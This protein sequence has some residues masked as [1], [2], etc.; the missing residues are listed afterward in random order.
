MRPNDG[1]VLRA[2]AAEWY[3]VRR[4]ERFHFR[5]HLSK[6]GLHRRDDHDAYHVGDELVA[7]EPHHWYM[8]IPLHC[9]N[10]LYSRESPGWEFRC[11]VA[12]EENL[13]RKRRHEESP[14]AVEL[15]AKLARV[16]DPEARWQNILDSK[17]PMSKQP[18][19]LGS[20]RLAT[21]AQ[22]SCDVADESLSTTPR[23]VVQRCCN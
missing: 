18:K 4:W 16:A 3:A 5:R 19:L 1:G 17:D 15:R 21:A 10:I 20:S 8:A 13:K 12:P 7:R 11:Q 6:R 23:R 14:E 22:N 2:A 9:R